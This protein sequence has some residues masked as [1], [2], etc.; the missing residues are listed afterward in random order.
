MNTIHKPHNTIRELLVHPKDKTPKEKKCGALYPIPCD[1]CEEFYVGETARPGEKRLKEH[2]KTKEEPNSI[3]GV[4]L[5]SQ[6]T[7]HSFSNDD[8]KIIARQDHWFKRKVLEAINIR[9]R[10][11]TLN[12]DQGYELP[13]IYRPL[14]ARDPPPGG[15]HDRRSNQLN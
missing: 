13:P 7:G 10:T 3:T 5:H 15:S 14:L 12:Q 8:V 4:G 2:R 11:P 9:T 1:T 6:T